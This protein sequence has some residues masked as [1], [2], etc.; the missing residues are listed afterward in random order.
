MFVMFK[1]NNMK[2]NFYL[3]DYSLGELDS[4]QLGTLMAEDWWPVHSPH[5]RRPLNCTY[6]WRAPENWWRETP[7]VLLWYEAKPRVPQNYEQLLQRPDNC[8]SLHN[9]Q[10]TKKKMKDKRREK[11]VS[12][13][14]KSLNNKSF[15]TKKQ[16]QQQ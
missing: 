11:K 3:P 16:K 13:F 7:A 9:S 8:S 10:L 6:P 2:D 12:L 14:I 4:R 15:I 5:Y 1:S